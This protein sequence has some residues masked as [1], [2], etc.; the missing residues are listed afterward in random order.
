MDDH[1]LEFRSWMRRRAALI[2]TLVLCLPIVHR[3]RRIVRHLCRHSLRLR[4]DGMATPPKWCEHHHED[5]ETSLLPSQLSSLSSSSSS[6]S[7][8]SSLSS[9]SN[10]RLETLQYGET[11]S[12]L[13]ESA[14]EMDNGH[15]DDIVSKAR[16]MSRA[17]RRKKKAIHF[18]IDSHHHF[19]K[20][21][22]S[23]E[24]F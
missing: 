1:H 20:Q 4:M 18:H 17:K 15:G 8:S 13:S 12:L 19:I 16:V 3:R 9:A 10:N 24:P 2:I 23:E 5:H 7:S 6:P 11:L 22:H 21:Y 14:A